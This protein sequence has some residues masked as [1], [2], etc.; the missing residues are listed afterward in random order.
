MIVI[1]STHL[2]CQITLQSKLLS[3]R[4]YCLVGTF[5]YITSVEQI[6]SN[7]HKHYEKADCA[8]GVIHIM[9]GTFSKF[10]GLT[11]SNSA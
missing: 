10:H 1:V 9:N 6:C 2:P 3:D 11:S 7:L 8:E 4:N 5:F